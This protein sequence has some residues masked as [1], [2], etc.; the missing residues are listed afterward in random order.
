M[1]LLD[2]GCRRRCRDTF[3]PEEVHDTDH[4]DH[5][6]GHQHAPENRGFAAIEPVIAAP[7]K[8]DNRKSVAELEGTTIQQVLLGTCTNG[9]LDDLAAAAEV[10][11]GRKIAERLADAPASACRSLT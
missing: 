8:V 1:G 5:R 7:H 9:R 4:H 3:D 2:K 11:E 10:L 6:A